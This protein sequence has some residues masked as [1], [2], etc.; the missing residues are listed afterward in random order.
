M[1]YF[2]EESPTAA[3]KSDIGRFVKLSRHAHWLQH[4][5]WVEIS[6]RT[7]LGQYL[8]FWG[9]EEGQIQ[10]SALVRR[11]RLPVLG[12]AKDTVER[13]PVCDSIDLMIESLHQLAHMLEACGAVSLT[14]NPYWFNTGAEEVENLLSEMGFFRPDRG[15]GPHSASL[16]IDLLPGE[17]EIL[18]SLRKKTRYEIR[19]AERL[20]IEVTPAQDETD[21]VAFCQLY[22]DSAVALGLKPLAEDYLIRLWRLLLRGQEDGVCLMA[23]YRGELVSADI[24]LKHGD[25]AEYTYAPSSV[26]KWPDVPKNHL[27]LWRT[28]TWAKARGCTT[29]DLGGIAPTAQDGSQIAGVNQFKQGFSD[30]QVRLV[31][32]HERVFRPARRTWLSTIASYRGRM[33][34][35]A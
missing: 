31:R 2:L 25:R 23:R 9:E 30:K 4:P 15:S 22:Q 35:T 17:E 34:P 7:R 32:E 1:K 11:M 20:G 10:V 14:V 24:V 3:E 19:K 6:G 8:F 5:L 16:V 21:I 12:W 27:C 28:L 29:Y 18:G 13:G 33:L 26:Q